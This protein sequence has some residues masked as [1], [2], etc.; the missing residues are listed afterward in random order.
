MKVVITGGH[1]SSALPVIKQLKKVNPSIEFFWIGHKYSISGDTNTTLEYKDITDLNIPFYALKAGKVYKTYNPFKLLKV[2]FGFFQALFFLL[3]IKPNI[4]LS[5]GGYLSVPVVL[6]GFLLNIPSVTHEQTIV[7]GWANKVVS[8]FA[9]KIMITWPNSAQYFPQNKTI[10]T[11]LPLRENVFKASTNNFDLN[12]KLPTVYLTAGK[13][14]SHIINSV[15]GECLNEILGM[16]NLIHQCGDSSLYNDYNN[17]TDIYSKLVDG[18]PGKYILKK[19]IRNGEI[20]EVFSKADLVLS[21]SGAHITYE[22]IALEK[23]CILIPIPW[24]SHNEQYENA[25]ILYKSGLGVILSQKELSKDTLLATL[26]FTLNNMH[27]FKIKNNS[28]KNILVQDSAK[29]IANVVLEE[30]KKNY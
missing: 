20:G 22:L 15:I 29:K 5:F 26:R 12:K 4:I 21:R 23:P 14:G 16:C 27:E 2:P 30:A 1:H 11:G 9:K 17:L 3:K 6:A 28:Y 8:K 7:V 19:F 18:V 13:Q 25:S 10:F 24:V